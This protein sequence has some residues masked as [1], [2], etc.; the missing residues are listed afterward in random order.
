MP[1]VAIVIRARNEA[2]LLGSTLAAVRRQT[3]AD[4]ETI[5]IDS[6][7][8]D[9]TC[10]IALAAGAHLLTIRP[11]DFSYGRALNVAIDRTSA[12]IVVSLSAHATPVTDTWLAHLTAP[13]A[14]DRVGAVYGRHVPRLNA[15]RLEVL[16]MRVSGTLSDIRRDQT[17]SIGFSNTNGALRRAL[18]ERWP[19]DEALPGAEDYAWARLIVRHGWAIVYEPR[20][21]VYHSHGESLTALARRML[22]DQPVIA[23]AWLGLLPAQTSR[24][25]RP[26]AVQPMEPSRRD[27]LAPE[28]GW[29]STEVVPETGPMRP[30]ASSNYPA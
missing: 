20:A 22:Q 14:D 19:F 7:S 21:A 4:H 8:S 23:R 10:A 27:A 1:K 26:I 17:R 29:P 12:P 5:V 11:T 3:C 25:R 9:E 18:W 2:T 24:R 30:S 6:G 13:L 15:T 16:G 28:M